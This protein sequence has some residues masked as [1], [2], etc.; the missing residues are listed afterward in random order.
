MRCRLKTLIRASLIL[1]LSS[2]GGGC[3]LFPKPVV[4]DGFC[5]R[6]NRVINEKGDGAA[7]AS[8]KKPGPKRATYANELTYRKDCPVKV[9]P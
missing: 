7:I 1:S 5:E 2:F 4:I 3:A 9:A 6:Y 8:I